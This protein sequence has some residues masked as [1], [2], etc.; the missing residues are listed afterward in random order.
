MRYAVISVIY[1]LLHCFFWN[2]FVPSPYCRPPAWGERHDKQIGAKSPLNCQQLCLRTESIIISSNSSRTSTIPVFNFLPRSIEHILL[3][4]LCWAQQTTGWWCSPSE[5]SIK[6]ALRLRHTTIGATESSV[7]GETRPVSSHT[8]PTW[9]IM[10]Y[11][12]VFK[13]VSVLG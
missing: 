5:N 6:K 13:N 8:Y 12:E 9:K 7:P 3:D 4:P 10:D 11:A 1:K 2:D